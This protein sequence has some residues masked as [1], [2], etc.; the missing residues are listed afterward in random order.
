MNRNEPARQD[1]RGR[2]GR[3][4]EILA[5]FVR[6]VSERG[7]ERTNFGDIAG[8]LGISKGTIVHHFG[9]KG[10]M[11][12]EL[13][14]DYM[15]RRHWEAEAL[16]HAAGEPDAK[17]A[18][19]ICAFVHYQ[20]VDRTATIAFQREMAQLLDDAALTTVRKQRAEYRRIVCDVIYEGISTGLFRQCDADIVSLHIFGSVHW[21]W[22]WFDPHGRASIENITTE[23]I[24]NIL[25]GLLN[26][27]ANL[28]SL[29]D[30]EGPVFDLVRH[31]LDLPAQA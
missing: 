15:R 22:T 27:H 25:G 4:E 12:R 18:A 16:V 21:M 23:Y 28:A 7:F 19:L 9:T 31:T 3:R 6:H 11:M 29:S 1:R 2:A 14:E 24:N 10:A 13:Q 26:D 8:E 5:T 30:P 17:L 20:V